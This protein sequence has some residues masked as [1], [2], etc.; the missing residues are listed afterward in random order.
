MY[1]SNF[2]KTRGDNTRRFADQNA[3]FRLRQQT[4]EENARGKP[5]D[6][7]SGR[8]KDR[9]CRTADQARKLPPGR[10]VLLFPPEGTFWTAAVV[11]RQDGGI[12][13]QA[14]N[15]RKMRG[16]RAVRLFMPHEKSLPARRESHRGRPVYHVLPLYQ[17]LPPKG[18][19]AARGRGNRAVPV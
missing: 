14:E 6:R 9:S 5:G 13:R 15:Q 11:L 3:G 19:H 16:L 18:H 17:P 4:A 1:G 12:H 7:P 2:K 8:P 10:A